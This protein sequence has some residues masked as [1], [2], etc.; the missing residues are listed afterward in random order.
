M[1]IYIYIYSISLSLSLSLS[2]YLTRRRPCRDDLCGYCEWE[3]GCRFES[4]AKTR[5]EINKWGKRLNN[6]TAIKQTYKATSN[7]KQQTIR[8]RRA[9]EVRFVLQRLQTLRVDE[10]LET[11]SSMISVIVDISMFSI[12]SIKDY[13]YY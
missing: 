11:S 2:G 5:H 1:R 4:V 7:Y 13:V 10:V 9:N 6:L 8:V 3:E 12:G